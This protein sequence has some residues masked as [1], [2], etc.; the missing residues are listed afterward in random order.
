MKYLLYYTSGFS[1]PCDSQEGRQIPADPERG[2]P[3]E[4]RRVHLQG[5]QRCWG[6]LLC[7]GALCQGDSQGTFSWQVSWET[8]FTVCPSLGEKEVVRPGMKTV[9]SGE[10]LGLNLLSPLFI[11][12]RWWAEHLLLQRRLNKGGPVVLCRHTRACVLQVCTCSE[13]HGNWKK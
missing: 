13:T 2:D 7:R 11:N 6:C 1:S 9:D 8:T 12:F 4:C 3:R 10:I 5:N